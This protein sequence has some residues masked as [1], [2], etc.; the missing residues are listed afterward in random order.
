M[1]GFYNNYPVRD[2]QRYLKDRMKGFNV[3]H[4]ISTTSSPINKRK[5]DDNLSEMLAMERNKNR[6]NLETKDRLQKIK[7]AK[8]NLSEMLAMKRKKNAEARQKNAEA[9]AKKRVNLKAQQAKNLKARQNKLVQN[10]RAR[11]ET[12]D[13]TY[14]NESVT[15]VL[16]YYKPAINNPKN[17]P[18]EVNE[19]LKQMAVYIKLPEKN[20]TL[21]KLWI[22]VHPDQAAKIKNESI[23]R[24]ISNKRIFQTIN[25]L[26]KNIPT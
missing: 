20:W 3:P 23:K 10:L 14:E 2:A 12:K 4:I 19:F 22:A 9:K 26:K 16:Q 21:R 17:Y 15:R 7:K 5:R 11:D 8:N 13:T 25:K 18:A 1:S 6:N 24:I